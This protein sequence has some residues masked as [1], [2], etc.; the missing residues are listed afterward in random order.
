MEGVDDLARRATC[1]FGV[2]RFRCNNI[3]FM[4][5]TRHSYFH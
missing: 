3:E 2:G 4:E 1:S 5:K